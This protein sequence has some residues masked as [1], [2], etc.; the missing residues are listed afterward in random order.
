MWLSLAD[1]QGS[2]ILELGC[3]PGRVLQC[4]AGAGFEVYGVD[5]DGA[6][7]ERASRGLP[8][9]LLSR[10]HLLQADILAL[11]L[12]LRFPLIIS[13]CNTLAFF[14][15]EV[16]AP[17]FIRLNRHLLPGGILAFELPTF[18]GKEAETAGEEPLMAFVDPE[19]GHPVQLSV[20]QVSLDDPPA[21]DITWCYDELAA[22]GTVSRLEVP[23]HLYLFEPSEI[24]AMLRRA[25]FSAVDCQADYRGAKWD[26]QADLM[27]AI[28]RSAVGQPP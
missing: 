23:T 21:V 16:L 27:I 8:P 18:A 9:A 26:P 5:R 14:P 10:T 13:P 25:G 1:Q 7:L 17:L 15:R 20:H 11:E 12:D 4:L 6:M 3:G 22:D 19:T 24:K 28:A 2:P